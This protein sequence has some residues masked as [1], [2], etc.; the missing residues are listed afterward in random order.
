MI[1]FKIIARIV[2]FPIAI[3]FFAVMV[4][5]GI[6]CDLVNWLFDLYRS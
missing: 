4:I 1:W 6:F 3:V 5:G 2:F